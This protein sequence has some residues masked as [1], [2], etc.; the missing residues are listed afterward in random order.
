MDILNKLPPHLLFLCLKII[1]DL[2]HSQ[3]QGKRKPPCRMVE[4]QRNL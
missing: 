2:L 1:A 3:T 4:V